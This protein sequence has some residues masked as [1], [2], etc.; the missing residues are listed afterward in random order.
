MMIHMS[1]RPDGGRASLQ[2]SNNG[3]VGK[4]ARFVGRPPTPGARRTGAS[5]PSMPPRSP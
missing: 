3:R 5:T 2:A 1:W 4:A